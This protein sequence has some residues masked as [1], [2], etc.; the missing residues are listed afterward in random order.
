MRNSKNSKVMGRCFAELKKQQ[1]D[2]EVLC[3]TQ[4]RRLKYYG[5]KAVFKMV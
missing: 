1:S 2:G 3:G 4:N 5:G